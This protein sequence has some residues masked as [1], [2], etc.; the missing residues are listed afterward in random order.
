MIRMR[1]CSCITCPAHEGSCPELT[2]ARR[3]A[4][5]AHEAEVRRGSR[6]QRGYD[7]GH[8]RERER[9]RPH[10]EAGQVDCHAHV[11]LMPIKRILIGARWDLGHTDDRTAWTGPEH[12]R[13]NRAA[14]G[15]ASHHPA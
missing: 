6:Q 13:C 7:A 9:W 5:C 15:R 8:E 3:C 10:V 2:T 11:C 14:G 1:V 4:A 12:R